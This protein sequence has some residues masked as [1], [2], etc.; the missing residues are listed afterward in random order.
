MGTTAFEAND[1]AVAGDGYSYYTPHT[2]YND[3]NGNLFNYERGNADESS[4][5]S[6]GAI[7][8][9]IVLVVVV[10]GGAAAFF[11]KKSR[12]GR[13]EET[14][15]QRKRGYHGVIKAIHFLIYC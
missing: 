4:G 10:A 1:D 2:V 12:F 15:H 14:S 11:M 5:M 6:G 8:G 13:E 7:F 3:E 9:I